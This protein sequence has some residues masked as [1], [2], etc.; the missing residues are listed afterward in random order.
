MGLLF[1][2]KFPL[3]LS[4]KFEEFILGGKHESRERIFITKILKLIFCNTQ[5]LLRK[6]LVYRKNYC[7]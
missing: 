6:A 7:S 5:Y 2:F 1:N 3:K 4:N